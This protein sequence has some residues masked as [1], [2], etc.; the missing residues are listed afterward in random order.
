MEGLEMIGVESRDRGGSSDDGSS[1]C[2]K[3][4]LRRRC[5]THSLL[6]TPAERK[7][8]TKHSSTLAL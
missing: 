5:A 8:H 3:F 1:W 4:E 7:K 2:L 6:H